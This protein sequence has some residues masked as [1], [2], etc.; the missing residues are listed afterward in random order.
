MVQDPFVT[1]IEAIYA[2]ASDIDRWP[3][4]L[5][6]IADSLGD[7]GS[8]LI[9]ARDDGRFGTITSPSLGPMADE[10]A[11]DWSHRDIRAIRA[12]E[13]GYFL[14]RDV[15]TDR[16]VVTSREMETDPQYVHFL[17]KHGLKYFAAASLLPNADMT[18][19]L[20][21]QRRRDRPPFSEA[22]L[23]IIGR[24]ARHVEQAM[25]LSVRLIDAELLNQ[26]LG[27]SLARAAVGVFAIDPVGRVTFSNRAAGR[28]IGPGLQIRE[29]R[30]VA[31]AAADRDE[32]ERVI[33]RVT[34]PA[35]VETT[36]D[37]RPILIH[38]GGGARPLIVHAL[39]LGPTR[40]PDS[41]LATAS[42]ILLVTDP[43]VNEAL[44]PTLIRDVLGLTLG[45]ARVAASVGSGVGPRDTATALGISEH[46]VH[47]VLKRVFSKTAVSRQ[48]ELVLLMTKL[49]LG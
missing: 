46:T 4:A 3:L 36:S 40:L 19:A 15:I 1:A 28:L 31:T 29:G 42:G 44:D 37:I 34:R 18:M 20:S 25:R 30:L 49:S 14:T 10:Y 6:A 17:A 33:V 26:G 32:L 11:R 8:I 41:L 22:E 23:E 27:E 38:R 45:E 16:D 7:A 47:S 24:L 48:S 12:Q 9:Y 2:A 43:G 13:R 21:I 39:P 35:Y 5:A